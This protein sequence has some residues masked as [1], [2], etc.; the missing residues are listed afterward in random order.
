MM[1]RT[2]IDAPVAGEESP[3]ASATLETIDR[4]DQALE[5]YETRIASSLERFTNNCIR[6][7]CMVAVLV[8]VAIKFL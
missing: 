8:F 3:E 6:D 2:Q 1:T 7:T 4:I 5:R